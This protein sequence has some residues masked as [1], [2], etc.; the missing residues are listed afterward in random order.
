MTEAELQ[1]TSEEHESNATETTLLTTNPPPGTDIN[2][3]KNEAT[4]E[5]QGT[6][7]LPQPQKVFQQSETLP[8]TIQDL[9]RIPSVCNNITLDELI[10]IQCY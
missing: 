10:I 8:L 2:H 9:E 6:N 1:E 7:N 4:E 3:A 5:G